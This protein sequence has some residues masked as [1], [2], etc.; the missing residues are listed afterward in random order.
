[1]KQFDTEEIRK[2]LYHEKFRPQFHFSPPTG[3]HNDA[4]GPV[5][6]EGEYHLFYQHNPF[7]IVW[8]PMYWGHAVSKD[9]VHWQ[10]LP[11]ALEPNELG[12]IFSGT[13]VVDWKDSSG[14][15][16]GGHGLVAIFTQHTDEREVHSI[17][18]S[19]DKGRTWTLYEGNPV[20]QGDGSKEYKDYRDP[21][22]FWHEGRQKWIMFL[23]GGLYRI[24]SSDNLREWTYESSPGIFEEFPDVMHL[25]VDGDPE[26]KKWVLATAGYGYYVG[27][28]DGYRY[29][30]E[31]PYQTA[32]FGK[33]WQAPYYF[34]N[35]PDPSRCVWIG[36]MRDASSAPTFPWRCNFSMPRDLALKT[37]PFGFVVTQ[38]PSRE[39]ENLYDQHFHFEDIVLKPGENPLAGISSNT[40]DLEAEFS[41]EGDAEFGIEFLKG[42][43][44]RTTAKYVPHAQVA[45]S[46]VLRASDAQYE[47]METCFR[48][49][50]YG[51][52]RIL[53]KSCEAYLPASEKTMRIRIIADVSAV[54]IFFGDGEAVFSHSVY[55]PEHCKELCAFASGEGVTLKRCD[56]Y[57]IKSIW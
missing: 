26:K 24:Y 14:F 50:M 39:I 56:V 5:Y 22:V 25:A 45:V 11:I 53:A 10:N 15:F 4:N 36:W 33:S 18:F 55:P 9:L 21:R 34:A 54:E 29:K 7:D 44:V 40:F 16:D 3:W 43:E 23:G 52:E 13:I 12:T 6:Y 35:F 32:D 42:G 17:A 57:T 27:D 37:T 51:N 19:R 28:F 47:K 8:G 49:A 46:D 1:M 31:Q 2:N 38:W 41:F 20:L 30:A 48:S